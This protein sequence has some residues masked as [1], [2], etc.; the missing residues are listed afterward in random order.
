MGKDSSV[1]LI[2]FVVTDFDMILDMD[3]L[4]KYGAMIDCKE[5]MVN[6]GL[7]GEKPLYLLALCMDPIYL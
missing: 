3:W 4:A 5:N 7:E 6:L 1:D 2:G